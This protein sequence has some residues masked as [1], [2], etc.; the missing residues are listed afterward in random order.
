M[1]IS[2]TVFQRSYDKEDVLE[3]EEGNPNCHAC[4]QWRLQEEKGPAD[5]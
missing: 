2:H 4:L 3:T 5:L 1:K